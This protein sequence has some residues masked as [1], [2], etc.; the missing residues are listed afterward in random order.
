MLDM[1]VHVTV[2]KYEDKKGHPVFFTKEF[3]EYLLS[4][5]ADSRLDYEIRE[6]IGKQKAKIISVK[7]ST[8][9]LNL[10]TIEEW[11]TFKVRK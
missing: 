9:V 11:K 4:C 5:S 7:D 8:I 1:D 3:A 10:N 6:L 2:P